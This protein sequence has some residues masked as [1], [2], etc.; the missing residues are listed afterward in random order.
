MSVEKIIE[1][2]LIKGALM[3]MAKKAFAQDKLTMLAVRI[4]EKG[5]FTV[6]PYKEPVV[7]ITAAD[8]AKYDN[9]LIKYMNEQQD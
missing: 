3:K 5:E 7:V 8:K 1:N 4:N 9:L 2:K 6:D